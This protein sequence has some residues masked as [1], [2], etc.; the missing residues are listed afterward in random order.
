MAD[1][2]GDNSIPRMT[3]IVIDNARDFMTMSRLF[4]VILL[5]LFKIDV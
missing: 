2:T 4:I 5:Y 3:I 1:P